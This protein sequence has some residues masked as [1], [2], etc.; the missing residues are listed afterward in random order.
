MQILTSV[1]IGRSSGRKSRRNGTGTATGVWRWTAL[2]R[3]TYMFIDRSIKETITYSID[4]SWMQS[5]QKKR[6]G[7][8]QRWVDKSSV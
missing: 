7:K 2:V 4:Y 8:F 5:G 6:S 3:R 1:M